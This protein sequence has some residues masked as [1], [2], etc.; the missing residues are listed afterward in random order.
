L[1][2]DP[3]KNS[4]SGQKL[5]V[6][7]HNIRIKLFVN[8]AGSWIL[9]LTCRSVSEPVFQ[10]L[11]LDL[12]E[13]MSHQSQ[14]ELVRLARAQRRAIP[15]IFSDLTAGS[16]II[17]VMLDVNASFLF[18]ESYHFHLLDFDIGPIVPRTRCGGVT[19]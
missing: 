12:S 6:R 9:V 19:Q 10:P 7:I 15:L 13:T 17:K 1:E 4:K 2:P 11:P 14:D 18:T 5:L 16:K 3:N 8:K